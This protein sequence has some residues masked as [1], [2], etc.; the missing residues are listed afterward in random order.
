MGAAFAPPA[1]LVGA[2][3][4]VSTLP[5]VSVGHLFA[6]SVLALIVIAGGL[7]AVA[8]LYSRRR[9]GGV[10]ARAGQPRSGLAVLS[11]QSL[12]KDHHL[13]VVR[14][15]D[16]EILVGIAGSN[17]TFLSDAPGDA[18]ACAA[19]LE[20][21]AD[22][23]AEERAPTP[24]LSSLLAAMRPARPRALAGARAEGSAGMS[25]RPLLERLRDAT[26][27]R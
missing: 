26:E 13:A 2:A 14:W 24:P 3:G 4:K 23:G 25:Y 15:G 10:F 7:W 17:I 22:G 8:K 6:Q 27:R 5:D 11:R 21:D 20:P 16:R 9:N 12:G 19:P 18:L 1:A